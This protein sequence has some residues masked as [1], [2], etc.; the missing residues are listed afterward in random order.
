VVGRTPRSVVLVGR[1]KL[2]SQEIHETVL[3]STH[4]RRQ[5]L[6]SMPTKKATLH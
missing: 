2:Y 3:A 5:T 1:V 4:A 6:N